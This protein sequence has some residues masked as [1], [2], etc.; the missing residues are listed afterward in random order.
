MNV[1][2]VL[3]SMVCVDEIGRVHVEWHEAAI[4]KQKRNEVNFA[5]VMT[6]ECIQG[7][8][9]SEKKVIAATKKWFKSK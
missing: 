3:V 9:T 5:E 1:N 7:L 8:F 6:V 4:G 2:D